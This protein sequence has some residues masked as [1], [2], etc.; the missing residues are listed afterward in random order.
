MIFPHTVSVDLEFAHDYLEECP[1]II[2]Y[3][4]ATD[5]TWIDALHISDIYI[6][7][8]CSSIMRRYLHEN[9]G[10]GDMASTL[11][12]N[13]YH[14]MEP[15]DDILSSPENIKLFVEELSLLTDKDLYQDP[16][17]DGYGEKSSH[18]AKLQKCI[19]IITNYLN[20]RLTRGLEIWVEDD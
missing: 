15:D 9:D 19:T 14:G 11:T 3:A 18:I 8:I 16:H 13:I 20:D 1:G 12:T 4:R 6:D 7:P 5:S 2:F 17:L 10:V